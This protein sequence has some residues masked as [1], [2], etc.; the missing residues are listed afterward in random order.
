MPPKSRESLRQPL[1]DR[2]RQRHEWDR[3]MQW[4]GTHA[5]TAWVFRGHPDA[6]YTLRPSIGRS[7]KYSRTVEVR[8]T[9]LFARRAAEFDGGARRDMWDMLTLGQHH[10]LPTRLLDWTTN[11]LVAAYFAVVPPGPNTARIIAVRVRE[12]AVIDP[13]RTP[14]P[15]AIESLGF[16][17]P[18]SLSTRVVRQ[19]GL[20][21]V[22]PRPT[23]AWEEPLRNAADSFNIAPEFHTSFRDRLFHLGVDARMI[24]GGLEGLGQRLRWQFEA[25]IGLGAI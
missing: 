6:A 21:S 7:L 19:S 4:V 22:H 23:E 25:R 10:G 8:L 12:T 2:T 3:F 11:P 18:R 1:L 17:V 20:F 15:F 16:L 14:D 24:Y 9:R 5:G 13:E